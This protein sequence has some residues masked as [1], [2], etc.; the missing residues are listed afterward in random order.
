MELEPPK[1]S[2]FRECTQPQSYKCTYTCTCPPYAHIHK[3]IPSYLSTLE[4]FS[5]GSHILIHQTT[6]NAIFISSVHIWMRNEMLINT[7]HMGKCT[8]KEVSS[9]LLCAIFKG[10]VLFYTSVIWAFD[11]DFTVWS[12]QTYPSPV[13]VSAPASMSGHNQVTDISWQLEALRSSAKL[14]PDA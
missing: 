14:G 10:M 4:W 5:S 3:R 11:A 8:L 6:E 7:Q 13:K 12:F 1:V 9:S 2:S